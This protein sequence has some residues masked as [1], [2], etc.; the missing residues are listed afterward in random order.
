LILLSPKAQN[1]M[2]SSFGNMARQ[3]RLQGEQSVLI[4]PRDA[5]HRGIGDGDAVVIANERGDVPAVARVT[6]AVAPGVVVASV[7]HWRGLA[8]GRA[9]VNAITPPGFADMGNAPTLS[10]NA[11]EVHRA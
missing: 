4:H 8:G 10:D 9:T 11:V 6:D 7:G 1:Y 3:Q 5:D 2:N